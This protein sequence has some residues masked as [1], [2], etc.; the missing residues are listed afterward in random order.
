M[1]NNIYKVFV[2]LA[3]LLVIS[4][5]ANAALPTSGTWPATTL[6]S[7]ETV[8]LDG[9]VTLTGTIQVPVGDTLTINMASGTSGNLKITR[10]ADVKMFMINGVLVI[11]GIDDSKR[12]VVDGNYT[13]GKNG[14]GFQAKDKGNITMNYVDI[15][16]IYYANGATLAGGVIDMS[17][18]GQSAVSG[19]TLSYVNIYKC[20]LYAANS[21]YDQTANILINGPGSGSYNVNISN[22]VFHDNLTKSNDD[23]AGGVIRILE[24]KKVNVSITDSKFYN[25]SVKERTTDNLSGSGGA[26]YAGSSLSSLSISGCEFYNN[27]AERGGALA[28]SRNIKVTGLVSNSKFHNNTAVNGGAIYILGGLTL[29]DKTTV[30]SNTATNGGGIYS[31]GNSTDLVIKCKADIKNNTATGNGGGIY[32]YWSTFNINDT[33]EVTTYPEISGNQ[34]SNGGAIYCQRCK[35]VVNYSKI[36]NNTAR[37][38]SDITTAYQSPSGVNGVGGGIYVGNG[39]SSSGTTYRSFLNLLYT[40]RL[41]VF[42]NS[43]D[44]MADDIFA[45][46][47]VTNITVP[48]LAGEIPYVGSDVGS[49][50][51]WYEDYVKNDTNYLKHGSAMGPAAE[52]YSVSKFDGTAYV[53]PIEKIIDKDKYVALTAG[54]NAAT[55]IVSKTGLKLGE[56]SIYTLYLNDSTT[57]YG[58]FILT[59]VDDNGTTVSKTVKLKLEGKWKVSESQTWAWQLNNTPSYIEKTVLGGASANYDFTSTAK[60]GVPMSGESLVDNVFS[61]EAVVRASISVKS[62]EDIDG[63]KIGF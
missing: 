2:I 44:N 26:I 1:R 17:G 6:T 47:S 38:T 57:P 49:A 48:D 10:G 59:G 54:K 19:L 20:T 45:S 42:D 61:P 53:V 16:D 55:I 30:Y 56:S 39:Y 33:T 14:M 15:T 31:D 60:T 18:T 22:C 24:D 46:A 25:N 13:G 41:S 21:S 50:S 37:K 8:A 5:S 32:A 11:N 23:N 43:A 28:T 63:G 52:R 7:N 4:H 27:S 34:A 9:D 3:F 12:I 29:D 35:F 40:D 36:T 51:N 62:R 58:R